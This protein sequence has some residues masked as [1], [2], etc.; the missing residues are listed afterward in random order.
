MNCYS[1]DIF[2]SEDKRKLLPTVEIYK[3][4]ES[5]HN[6]IAKITN[7]YRR[8]SYFEMSVYYRLK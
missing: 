1:G 5:N 3:I 8:V 6:V 2:W 7:R 4:T